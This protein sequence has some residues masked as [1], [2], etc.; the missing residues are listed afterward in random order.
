MDTFK[1]LESK[2]TN[3]L[4]NNKSKY[5][6]NQLNN[7][8]NRIILKKEYYYSIPISIRTENTLN[9]IILNKSNKVN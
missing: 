6:V 7:L 5:M 8:L 1:Q 2:V 9:K 3:L 4:S